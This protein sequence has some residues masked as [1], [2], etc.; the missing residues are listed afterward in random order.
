MDAPDGGVD[1]ISG[2]VLVALGNNM[3][4]SLFSPSWY[5]VADLKPRL[6]AHVRIHR[7]QY[8]G[9]IWFVLQDLSTGRF[10]RFM[11]TTHYVIGL[12]DGQRTAQEIWDEAATKFGDEAPT[13]GE[14]IELL[15]R[16]HAADLL[17][18]NVSPSNVEL[19]ER[20]QRQARTR[21]KSRVWNPLALRIPVFDPE[22]LLS[23]LV[24]AVRPLFGWFGVGVW[25]A[26]VMLASVLAAMHWGALTDNV[27]DRVLTANNLFLLWLLYPI[28]K[29]LHE[30]GH[31]FAAKVWGG[32]VHEM[33]LMFL[34]LIPVPYVD[35]SSASAFPDKKKR[36]LVGAAGI[37]VEVFVAGLAMIL[38]ASVEPGLVRTIAF[39]TMLIA[40]VSTLFF[41]GNP[42]LRFDGYY[43][44]SDA[45][46]IPNLATQS[47]N[48]LKELVQRYAFGV[49]ELPEN[50]SSPSERAWF[51]FYGIASFIYRLFV[52]FAIIVMIA[53]KFFVVGVLLAAWAVLTQIAIPVGKA[54]HFTIASPTL[55]RHRVRAVTLTGSTV[56]LI[57]AGLLVVPVPLG[58]RSEGVIWLPE[59]SQI[60]VG[61]DCFV[62]RLRVAD[63]ARV[64]S[65]DTLID[66]EDRLL[67]ANAEVLEAKLQELQAR[68]RS[69]GLDNRVKA[70]IIREEIGA[71]EAELSRAFER[72]DA[73]TIR[74][75]AGGV[76]VVPM[77]S[78]LL[79]RFVPQGE[80]IA[81]VIDRSAVRVRT[82]VSQADIGLVR[83]RTEGVAVRRADKIGEV[84]PAVLKR[85]VPEATYQLP[86][87]A[88]GTEGGGSIVVDP[89]DEDGVR[90]LEKL[91]QL[92]LELPAELPPEGIGGR[93]YVRF[94]HGSEPLAQRWYR[95]VRRLF[96][97]QFDV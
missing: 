11:P 41:N 74:S 73:L 7:H 23:L 86:S 12:M 39:N 32:E 8:R 88:L 51:L 93:V 46:E 53:G 37:L 16:L 82:V 21:W 24:P 87:V 72:Q 56:V 26:V 1:A 33:G 89:E 45:I 14:M 95:S 77:A 18:S 50:I 85:Q 58:T 64:Q 28:V 42:L 69:E 92:E 61:T 59:Q 13:Q 97:R 91:F 66:C 80:L 40:G 63:G 44:L 9:R 84:I 79:G 31:A 67:H 43:V 25:I 30:L 47:K 36:M 49:R 17:V 55:R 29:A 62:S 94:D 81:Y 70:E 90:S 75:P 96:L 35:A 76:L 5:R 54:I 6:R 60:R 22:K 78:D 20:Y 3:A 48:Y 68:L 10:H 52:L 83:Q 65:G 57:L 4:E 2:L 34:V 15:S 71:V 38:W 27:L 19:F